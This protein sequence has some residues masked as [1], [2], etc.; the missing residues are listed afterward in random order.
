MNESTESARVYRSVEEFQRRFYPVWS[1]TQES[2]DTQE[3]FGRDLARYS[4]EKHFPVRK[5]S[6]TKGST[7]S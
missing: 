5:G 6:E 2:L 1:K 7:R 3:S 4:L